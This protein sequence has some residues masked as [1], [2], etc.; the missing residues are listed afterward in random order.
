MLRDLRLKNDTARFHYAAV[1][2]IIRQRK[3]YGAH[4]GPIKPKFQRQQN[5][6]FLHKA[7]ALKRKRQG[8]RIAHKKPDS[9]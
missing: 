5:I 4:L 8:R 2:F 9:K 6:L 1:G 7:Q 3:I